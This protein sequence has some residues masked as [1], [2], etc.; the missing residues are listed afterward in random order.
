MKI[1]LFFDY[2]CH[3]ITDNSFLAIIW[4]LHFGCR[5]LIPSSWAGGCDPMGKLLEFRANTSFLQAL[6]LG[7][8]FVTD[9]QSVLSSKRSLI[10]NDRS[11][12]SHECF[13]I[14][15]G[16]S[17]MSSERFVHSTLPACDS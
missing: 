7:I 11:S 8:S 2:Y 10:S 13:L 12:E 3:L 15:D 17:I 9:R 14:A 16:Q 4:A 6:V 1:K 5:E